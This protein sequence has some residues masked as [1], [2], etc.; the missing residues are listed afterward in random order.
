MLCLLTPPIH[1][2]YHLRTICPWQYGNEEIFAKR[3]QK[4]S[5]HETADVHIVSDCPM[6]GPSAF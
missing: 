1:A 4:F 2:A 5:V 6:S 3:L